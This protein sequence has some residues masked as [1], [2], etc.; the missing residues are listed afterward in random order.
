MQLQQR[1]GDWV[2]ISTAKAFGII[3]CKRTRTEIVGCISTLQAFLQCT[4]H[5]N[6]TFGAFS[7]C[8]RL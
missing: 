4:D 5:S 7:D 6:F 1:V 3:W 8:P 2:E